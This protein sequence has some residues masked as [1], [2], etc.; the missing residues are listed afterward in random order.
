LRAVQRVKKAVLPGQDSQLQRG[1]TLDTGEDSRSQ[2]MRSRQD[3]RTDC[4]S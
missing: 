1:N 4:Q 3:I 2:R